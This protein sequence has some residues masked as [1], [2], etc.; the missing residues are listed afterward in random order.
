MTLRGVL[1]LLLNFI[2][3]LAP[4][5]SF[6]VPAFKPSKSTNIPT[7]LRADF[8]NGDSIKKVINAKGHVVVR[9]DTST[10]YADEVIYDKNNQMINAFGHVKVKNIEIGD[11]LT[12]RAMVKDDFSSGEFLDSKL[13]LHDGSYFFADKI[14]KKNPELT[15]LEKTLYSFCPNPDINSNNYKESTEDEF[16]YIRTS[17]TTINNEKQ[18]IKGRHGVFYLYNVP[19]FYLPYI[20][21]PIPAKE[22]ESG[23]LTP[24]YTKTT[25]FGVGLKTPY[26]FNIAENMDLTTT[27]QFSFNGDQIMIANKFR[28]KLNYGDYEVDF[29]IAN[30]EI[31]SNEDRTVVSRTNKEYRWDLESKAS[32]DFT[33]DKALDIDI[34]Y[35]SDRDYLRDYHF[36]YLAYTKSEVGLNYRKKRDYHSVKTIKIQELEDS[37]NEDAAVLALPVIDSHIETRPFFFKEKFALTSNFTAI[38]REDGL[39]YRRLT[40]TPE[41][42]VPFNLGGN[43]FK[44]SARLQGDFYS[45]DNNFKNIQRDND[46]K[47]FQN[48]IKPELSLSWSLPLIKKSKYNTLVIEPIASIVASSS[49]KNYAKLPNEDSNDSELTVNNLFVNDRISGFDRNENGERFNYGVKTS[50]FNQYGE[51]GFTIGQGYRKGNDSQDVAIRGFAGNNKS[52]IVGQILYKA[53][54]HFSILYVFQLDQSDYQNDINQVTTSLNYDSFS[55]SSDYLLI[56]KTLQNAQE[57]E[58]LNFNGEVKLG[59][60]WTLG[61]SFTRDLII[62]RT[63]SRGLTLSREGCCTVFGF[64]IIENNQVNLIKPQKS[65]N[66]SVSFKNL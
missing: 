25:N 40:T 5:N 45:L 51:F 58:Q 41:V 36:D 23:F 29:E 52:N 21:L 66:L 59:S 32:F 19:V 38:S 49:S 50:L 30:N 16:A 55:I 27:P 6:A 4:F 1:F 48:N 22:R 33:T 14:T 12:K 24:T 42:N 57:R 34:N 11:M 47:E 20:K 46:F 56:R 2:I 13:F 43:L 63:I 62:D 31:T 35:I 7:V 44:A 39:Q 53:M 37:G 15:V 64:S 61:T 26:Y 65:F 3:L 18:T 60:M 8:V 10:I 54:R 9:K 17:S 28:H